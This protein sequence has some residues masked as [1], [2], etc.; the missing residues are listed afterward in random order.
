MLI[1]LFKFLKLDGLID[2]SLYQ[3]AGEI[4]IKFNLTPYIGQK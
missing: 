3:T 1:P 4:Q 2:Y